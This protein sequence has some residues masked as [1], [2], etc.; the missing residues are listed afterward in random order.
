MIQRW[1]EC[2]HYHTDLLTR[3]L[4]KVHFTA[5]CAA[6]LKSAMS[7]RFQLGWQDTFCKQHAASP[8]SS[9]LPCF[10]QL[11]LNF[12]HDR[13]KKKKRLARFMKFEVKPTENSEPFPLSPKKMRASVYCVC[14]TSCFLW[15]CTMPV[16][17]GLFFPAPE[18]GPSS[19]CLPV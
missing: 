9:K 10:L 3:A 17:Q 2:K 1:E 5:V 13:K 4:K 6:K 12:V 14:L 19:M 15:Y 18:L 16:L 11:P 8:S 7:S